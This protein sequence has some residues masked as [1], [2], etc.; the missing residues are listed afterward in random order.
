M[1]RFIKYWFVIRINYWD[2]LLIAE[3]T[4]KLYEA[5]DT[6]EREVTSY[7]TF[8]NG[9]NGAWYQFKAKNVK[10]DNWRLLSDAQ[11]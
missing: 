10:F 11:I 3:F 6:C 4:Y 8:V 5:G 2:L 9:I 7:I 1:L